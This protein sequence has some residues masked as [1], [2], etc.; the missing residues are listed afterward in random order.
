MQGKGALRLDLGTYKSTGTAFWGQFYNPCLHAALNL[1]NVL[2]YT[3]L[4]CLR[5]SIAKSEATL[6]GSFALKERVVFAPL[7]AH[8]KP[9]W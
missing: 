8:T 9:L 4:N 1:A 3:L 6:H 5:D 2:S 7:T